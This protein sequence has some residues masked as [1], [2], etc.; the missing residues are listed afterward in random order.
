VIVAALAVLAAAVAL[1]PDPG[2]LRVV[3]VRSLGWGTPGAGRRRPRPVPEGPLRRWLM[4]TGAAVPVALLLGGAVGVG[5]GVVVLLGIERVLCRSQ[6]GGRASEARLLE[7]LPVACD[8][9][10][11]CL[12]AGLPL[13]GA[14][15][16]VAGAVPGELGDALER[17][18]GMARLGADAGRAWHDAPAVL[19]PLARTL[20][21]SETSGAR[22]APALHALAADLRASARGATDAAVQR[23]GV[24]ILAPLGLCFL[25]AFVCL[26]IAPLVIGIAGDVLG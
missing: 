3:R 22:A 12:A 7:P 6:D 15:A 10:A 17:V 19:E 26:G 14:L 5:A 24:R 23:A 1:W 8:L 13:P 21:R 25:P 9:L 11:V 20:R 2:H 4:A 16:A 18:A